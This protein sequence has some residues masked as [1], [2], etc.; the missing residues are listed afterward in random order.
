M[1]KSG[2]DEA[3]DFSWT[4]SQRVTSEFPRRSTELEQK[5]NRKAGTGT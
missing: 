5:T 2:E 4:S 3:E 1:W